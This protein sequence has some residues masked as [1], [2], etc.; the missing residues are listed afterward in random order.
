MFLLWARST[1]WPIWRQL[2]RSCGCVFLIGYTLFILLFR[3][4]I[5]TSHTLRTKK[6]S[7]FYEMLFTICSSL[8]FMNCNVGSSIVSQEI[9]RSFEKWEGGRQVLMTGPYQTT[10]YLHSVYLNVLPG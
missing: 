9:R 5:L 2:Y 3:T 7:V 8:L 4:L 6:L 1:D 10:L